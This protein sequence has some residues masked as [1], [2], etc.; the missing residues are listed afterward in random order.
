LAD[1]IYGS[2]DLAIIDR[3]T[4]GAPQAR[5]TERVGLAPT[6]QRKMWHLLSGL[7]RCAACGS[8]M[9]TFGADRPGR[10]RLRCSR[11]HEN[12][13]CPK[14][15][16]FYLDTVARTVLRSPRAE[17][18][19]PRLIAEYV[20]TC[21]EERARFAGQRRRDHAAQERAGK[22]R[23]E[24]DRLV[25]ALRQPHRHSRRDRWRMQEACAEGKALTATLAEEPETVTVRRDTSRNGGIELISVLNAPIRPKGLP[26][27][28][29]I[30]GSGGRI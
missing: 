3:A 20:R 11:A 18:A 28:C 24:I 26:A 13:I 23:R 22:L 6:Y 25:E 1:V 2:W 4:F 12:G 15:E 8:G 19:D 30:G 14:P 16:T 29:G 5:L 7:L 17:L 10:K 27:W 9:S 21:R